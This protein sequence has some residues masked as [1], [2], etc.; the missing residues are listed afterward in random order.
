MEDDALPS[1]RL[2]GSD[3]FEIRGEQVMLDARVAQAFGTETKR[4]NEAVS[5]N[6]E[7]F[8]VAH[9][10]QLSPAEHE[11]L[12]SQ[13]ATSTTGRGGSRYL[14]HVFTIK[15]IARL[16]TVLNTNEALRAT[17]LII[18][19]FLVVYE[20]ISQ[21]RTRI[22]I[23]EPSQYRSSPENRKAIQK[24]RVRLLKA[25]TSL[26][27]TVVDVQSK[28]TLR[29][30]GQDLGSSALQHIQERLRTKGL[31][32]AKLEADVSLILAQAEQTLAATRKVHAEADSIDIQ[33]LERRLDVV[34]KLI[35]M[36]KELEPAEFVEML[37]AFEGE[38]D[39]KRL[40]PSREEKKR[41]DA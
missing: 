5:R 30:V 9:T 8:G 40:A 10:F 3:I 33:N 25:L 11:A 37:D 7:K 38:Q 4:I 1:V 20:Q 26:L 39:V 23:P 12:R 15:G 32:N 31:Q 24:F 17:D 29:D 28:R 41:G 27:D 6:P 19:T 35:E 13:I 2:V 18:D 14:P 21:G 36:S 34:K 16:A 22:A